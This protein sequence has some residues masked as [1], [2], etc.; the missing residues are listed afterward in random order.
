MAV[1]INKNESSSESSTIPEISSRPFIVS[2]SEEQVSSS[3]DS[4]VIYGLSDIELNDPNSINVTIADTQAPL[5]VL[6]GPPACGKTMTLVRLTRFLNQKGYTVAP[7]RTFRPTADTNYSN[8][9]NNFNSMINSNDAASGTDHI[10]FMLVEVLKSGKRI[11]QIL[12]APGEY[13]FKP[14]DPN[15][16][17]PT[18]VNNI[19]FSKNRKIWSIMVEPDWENEV[20]RRNYV[21]RIASLRAQMTPKDKAVFIFNKIDK[22]NFVYSIGE[23]NRSELIRNVE[24]LYPN[25]FVPFLNQN[26]ITKYWKKYNCDL[27]PFQTGTY[28]QGA[29]GKQFQQGPD[30]NGEKLWSG[31]MK[32]IYG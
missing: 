25:I 31:L 14:K 8:I 7:I 20:D 15:K 19:I 3:S 16:P 26:P 24:Y 10:S 1:E 2:D 5:V 28:T 23:I 29:K 6:F 27:E 17:F 22:T 18:Y 21:T 11:C 9:C 12:E 4:D 30:V 32:Q 13:Y